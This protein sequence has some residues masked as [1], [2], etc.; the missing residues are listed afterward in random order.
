MTAMIDTMG[1]ALAERG[2]VPLAGLRLGVQRVIERRLLE[3]LE[4]HG[5]PSFERALEAGPLALSTETANEQHY[6]VPAEFF[7]IVLG[8]RLKYSSGYW[9]EGVDTLARAEDAMLGLTCERA[10]LEDGQDVLELGCG[11]GSLTLHMAS[12]YPASRITAVSNS[13][14]QRR[15]IEQRAPSN[16]RVI[17]ADVNDLVLADRFDRVVSVEMFEHMR[18]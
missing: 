7:E 13:R 11:W 5:R 3:L 6:E 18:N 14:A 1:V 12:A 10:G 15:F 8:P 4:G 16:V 17:T 2:L 9:P